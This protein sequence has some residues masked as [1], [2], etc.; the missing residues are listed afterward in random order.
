MLASA[1]DENQAIKDQL[2]KYCMYMVYGEYSQASCEYCKLL[3]HYY[4]ILDKTYLV[5]SGTEAIE[6]VKI[7]STRY[8]SQLI[9]ATMPIMETIR[10]PLSIMF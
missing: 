10:A 2:D 5:N 8:R 3:H 6:G 9:S 1:C 7:S 4:R